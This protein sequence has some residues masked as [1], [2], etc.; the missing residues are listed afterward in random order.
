V[1]V[2]GKASERTPERANLLRDTSLRELVGVGN[3]WILDVVRD[4]DSPAHKLWIDIAVA[5]AKE[6]NT[7][8]VKTPWWIFAKEDWTVVQSESVPDG[9]AAVEARLLTYL[10]DNRALPKGKLTGCMPRTTKVGAGKFPVM[11]ADFLLPRKQWKPTSIREIVPQ[12][13]DQDGTNECCPHAGT[14]AMQDVRA[15]L[16]LPY[17]ELSPASVYRFGNG[18]RDAGMTIEDCLTILSE[19]G[20]LPTSKYPALN[21]RAQYPADGAAV[22]KGFRAVEWEDT[23]NTDYIGSAV[24]RGWPVVIGVWWSGGG[25]HAVVVT[26]WRPESPEWEIQNSWGNWGDS[27]FGH[28]PEGQVSRGI[29]SFGAWALRL[30]SRPDTDPKPQPPK[31]SAG[32]SQVERRWNNWRPR[33]RSDCPS[34]TCPLNTAP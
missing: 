28:L 25:G 24:Q 13:K 8:P 30:P 34:G 15:L 4:V 5:D 31:A 26:G 29:A 16:G 14:G 17:V 12:I 18:G 20:A 3:Y 10:N 2:I 1:V 33:S 32:S 6:I 27:G 9:H 7:D 22:A 21:W 11:A 19:R 23:I